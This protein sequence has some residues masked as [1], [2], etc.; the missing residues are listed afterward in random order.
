MPTGFARS[1][2]AAFV[3]ILLMALL[4]APAQAA[5]QITFWSKE[6]GSSFPH[7]FVTL[8]G[9]LDR[10]GEK[11]SEDYG[12]SAKTIS[13]AV[14]WGK[15]KGEVSSDHSLSYQEGSNR[16]FTLTLTDEEYDQ[17]MTAVTRWKTAKQPSYDL[18]KANCVHF[19]GEVAASLG[20]DGAPRKGMM[21]KP[22]SFL[23][24]VTE[25][26]RIWLAGRGATFHRPPPP[27]PKRRRA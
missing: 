27:E 20:M 22:R 10:S 19:V 13:P 18:D 25:A 21:R 8:E 7:A 15:V 24:A 23:N 14:L 12:F 16:H 4:A 26:N 9:T 2:L 17:V 11:I 3:A 5:V 6:F 1:R